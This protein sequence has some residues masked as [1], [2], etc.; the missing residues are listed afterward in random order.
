MKPHPWNGRAADG[1]D[2]TPPSP[3]LL[4]NRIQQPTSCCCLCC[5][6]LSKASVVVIIMILFISSLLTDLPR[7]GRTSEREHGKHSTDRLIDCWWR[8]ATPPSLPSVKTMKPKCHQNEYWMH[9][10]AQKWP[11][12]EL[13]Y[14]LFKVGH[15]RPFYISPAVC[16]QCWNASDPPLEVVSEAE[17]DKMVMYSN[18]VSRG[19]SHVMYQGYNV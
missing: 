18:G 2:G 16:V 5:T 15:S 11:G 19:N 6:A 8:W 13:T 1:V 9:I 12:S 10:Y 4:C 14:N 3:Q 17:L 7:Q